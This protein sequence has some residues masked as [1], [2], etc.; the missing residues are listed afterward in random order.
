MTHL[1]V[2]QHQCNNKSVFFKVCNSVQIYEVIIKMKIKGG[3]EKYSFLVLSLTEFSYFRFSCEGIVRL[4]NSQMKS[5][6][7][8]DQSS[9][10]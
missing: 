2:L 10:Q 4:S 6:C 8:L 9:Q 7:G 3:F 5:R 1:L